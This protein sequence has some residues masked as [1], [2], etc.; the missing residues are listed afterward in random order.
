M[1]SR[2]EIAASVYHNAH[3]LERAPH[4]QLFL[5]PGSQPELASLPEKP[6]SAGTTDKDMQPRWP[7]LQGGCLFCLLMEQPGASSHQHSL[8]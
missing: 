8:P 5:G 7:S 2:R 3:V 1:V 4:G 6:E